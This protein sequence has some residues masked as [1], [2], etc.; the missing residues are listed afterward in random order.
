MNLA[1]KLT[2]SRFFIIPIM[3]LLTVNWM[4]WQTQIVFLELTLS[5]FIF[6]IL[7]LLASFTDFLDG[8]IAR[9]TNT[10]TTFGK[11]LDPIA[12]KALVITAMIYLVALGEFTVWVVSVVV[13]REFIVSGL[14]LVAVEKK[15]VISAGNLGKQKTLWTMVALLYYLFN[16]QQLSQGFGNAL[17]WLFVILTIISGYEYVYKNRAL[18]NDFK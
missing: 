18:L 14:R 3:L 12:D 5:Q 17:V 16:L 6:A 15:H 10:I 9:K 13:L 8:Y 11:F 4:D 7:F 1:N 2:I